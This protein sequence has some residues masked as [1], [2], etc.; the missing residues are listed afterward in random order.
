MDRLQKWQERRT[1]K[2]QTAINE[3]KKRLMLSNKLTRDHS[4]EINKRRTMH[5]LDQ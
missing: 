1:K 2:N 5:D 4:V 3:D